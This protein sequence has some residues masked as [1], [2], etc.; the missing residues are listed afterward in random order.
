MKKVILVSVIFLLCIYIAGL[1][2]G[3]DA[4]LG[5]CLNIFREKH[6]LDV[7]DISEVCLVRIDTL[8]VCVKIEHSSI[9][10]REKIRDIIKFLSETPFTE[11]QKEEM[12]I[13]SPNGSIEFYDDKGNIIDKY[14]IYGNCYIEARKNKKIYRFWDGDLNEIL[15]NIVK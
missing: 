8:N 4:P 13:N 3:E 11:K 2:I 9:E 15:E 1:F 12:N 10:D 7:V 14:W 5:K 6:Y